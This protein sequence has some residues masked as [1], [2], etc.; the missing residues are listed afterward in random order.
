MT[1]FLGP[2]LASRVS[3]AT[4]ERVIP[5]VLVL[6]GGALIVEAFLAT[7]T[8]AI[9]PTSLWP[10]AAFAFGPAIGLVGSLLGVAGGELIIPKV[11]LGIDLQPT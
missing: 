5:V 3:N 1:A 9:V 6:I 8:T 11:A 7:A 10:I 2:A 4:L